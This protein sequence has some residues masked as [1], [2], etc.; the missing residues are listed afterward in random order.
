[1]EGSQEPSVNAYREHSISC[2]GAY[3]ALLYPHAFDTKDGSSES[4]HRP[5]AHARSWQSPAAA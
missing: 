4:A 5:S 1:M 3:A 2:R